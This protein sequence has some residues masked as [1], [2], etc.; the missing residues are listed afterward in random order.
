MGCPWSS[1][2]A[3]GPPGV[4]VIGGVSYPGRVLGTEL[5]YSAGTLWD[6]NQAISQPKHT[7]I[8][9]D[10]ETF[11]S[12]PKAIMVT[13]VFLQRLIFFFVPLSLEGNIFD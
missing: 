1:E 11:S 10:K 6:L 12:H 8:L 13:T 2:K 4:G 9:I 3:T 5:R 7:Q